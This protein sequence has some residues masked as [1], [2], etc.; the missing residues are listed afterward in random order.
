[1]QKKAVTF[2]VVVALALAGTGWFG[3]TVWKEISREA[4]TDM[5]GPAL[6]I[7]VVAPTEPVPVSTGGQLSVGELNNSYDHTE[8]MTRVEPQEDPDNF[9]TFDDQSW[10]DDVGTTDKRTYKSAPYDGFDP[11]DY[12]GVTGRIPQEG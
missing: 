12:T 6:K 2:L 1:M 7:D 3:W 9:V 10:P 8:A 5:G 11:D 4:D